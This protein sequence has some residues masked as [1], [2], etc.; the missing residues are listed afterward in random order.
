MFYIWTTIHVALL[1]TVLYLAVQASQLWQ[2]GLLALAAAFLSTQ[3]SLIV[4]DVLHG[5]APRRHRLLRK[6]MSFLLGNVLVGLSDDWWKPKHDDHHANPNHIDKDPDIASVFF[7]V[8][9]AQ[10]GKKGRVE[11]FFARHQ[12]WAFFCL[13][14]LQAF[15]FRKASIIFLVFK[16]TGIVRYVGLAGIGLHFVWYGTFLFLLGIPEGILFAVIHQVVFGVYNSLIFAPNHKGMPIIGPD[17]KLDSFTSQVITARNVRGGWIFWYV[18]GGLDL[19][20]EHHLFP[21]MSRYNLHR[22][23]PIVEQYCNETGTPYTAVGILAS[24]GQWIRQFR[25]V[26]REA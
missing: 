20:I 13:I 2:I 9:A 8:D 6:P 11:R 22:A 19:Q 7:A 16:K 18:S 4:H 5:Q 24:Y 12:H 25:S 23:Q 21:W 14:T 3:I 26:S 15:S 10:L 17:E 1:C